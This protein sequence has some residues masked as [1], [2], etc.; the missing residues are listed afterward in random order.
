MWR[1]LCNVAVYNTLYNEAVF[2][3]RVAGE[4]LNAEVL[5]QMVDL[6]RLS[7]ER[8][9][10]FLLREIHTREKMCVIHHA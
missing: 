4:V 5:K 8:V 1:F 9:L 10:D 6:V 3:E 2:R 7:D